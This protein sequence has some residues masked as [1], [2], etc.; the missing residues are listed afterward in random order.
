MTTSCDYSLSHDAHGKSVSLV[1]E[2]YS[3]LLFMAN[4]GITSTCPT[5]HCILLVQI[6]VHMLIT[7]TNSFC[8][9]HTCKPSCTYL[10]MYMYNYS[11]YIIPLT[12]TIH[13][14]PVRLRTS[15]RSIGQNIGH[16]YSNTNPQDH[17]N[18]SLKLYILTAHSHTYPPY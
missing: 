12:H 6:H 3:S 10:Y 13:I 16:R 2:K 4:G 11:L 1:K 18:T 9:N 8:I 7:M 15:D 5:M 17:G 14:Y